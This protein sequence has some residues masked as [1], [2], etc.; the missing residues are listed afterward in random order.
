MPRI[1]PSIAALGALLLA[2]ATAA[3]ADEIADV[4]RLV[5]A[6]QPQ[7]ALAAAER[8]LAEHPNDAAMRFQRGVIL[9]DLGRGD[10]AIDAFT[11]LTQ[12][13]PD[14]PEPYN[15][16]GVL[17]AARGDYDQARGAFEAA[18]RNN[19]GY[20]VAHENLG[21]IHAVLASRAYAQA[22]RL[23][24]ANASAPPKLALIRELLARSPRAAGTAAPAVRAPAS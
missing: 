13:F 19:P 17:L 21:D 18:I 2:V 7:Q 23:E 5:A 1:L 22:I 14:L 3:R 24:P 6:G 4:A 15:N 8:H 16:L 12:D 20:A 9:S 10:D 11:R